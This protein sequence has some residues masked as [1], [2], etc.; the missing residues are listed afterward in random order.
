MRTTSRH[1][2]HTRAVSID[3]TNSSV[4]YPPADVERLPTDDDEAPMGGEL[5]ESISTRKSPGLEPT[6][7]GWSG[8]THERHTP[9]EW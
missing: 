1:I 6:R 2:E 5:F 7:G 3:W 4:G 8:H 9:C